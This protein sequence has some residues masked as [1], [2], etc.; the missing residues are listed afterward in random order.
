MKVKK[1]WKAYVLAVM[2]SI[3][4]VVPAYANSLDD[5][6]GE[7]TEQEQEQATQE[8][9]NEGIEFSTGTDNAIIQEAIDANTYN[10]KSE[11]AT[12]ANKKI[13]QFASI[14]VQIL[15]YVITALL[16]VRVLL[17]LC[18]IV[19]PFSRSLLSN[20]HM[21]NPASEG[22]QQPGMGMGGFGGGYGGGFG[23]GYGSGFGMRS[24][25]GAM[26]ANNMAM[27]QQQNPQ[28]Q[29]RVQWVSTAALNAAASESTVGANGKA[30]NALK[31]YAKDM[32]PV[33][34]ITPIFLVLAI[35]GVLSNLGFLIGEAL[36]GMIGG[37]GSGI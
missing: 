26:G 29:T 1:T 5:V 24:G 35:T 25:M 36:A 21:G 13:K 4:P 37:F 27:Q 12:K 23:G 10:E 14:I 22:V 16:V 7:K 15:A 31:T 2:V 3:M 19:L 9:S 28:M 32:L 33:L 17:D 20:G 11:V 34:V 18:Y 8:F 6:I 30:N